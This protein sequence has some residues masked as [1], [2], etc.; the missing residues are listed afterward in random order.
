L[1][2]ALIPENVIKPIQLEP[3]DVSED[4]K[5]SARFI[6]FPIRI[7]TGVTMKHLFL[8]CTLLLAPLIAGCDQAEEPAK[9]PAAETPK[10]SESAPPKESA[11]PAAP[12]E[13]Q[14]DEA[15]MDAT[16]PDEEADMEEDTVEEEV[17]EAPAT[18]DS[19]GEQTQP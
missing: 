16:P 3:Q 1:T 19:P 2:K 4:E 18:T 14:M 17:I 6:V 11:T 12:A 7:G 5:P 9:E 10:P 8:I 13:E 15:P